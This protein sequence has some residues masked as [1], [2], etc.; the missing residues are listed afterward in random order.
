MQKKMK[1]LSATLPEGSLD[2][3]GPDD[4]FAKVMGKD[5]YGDAV[6]Y[7]LGVRASD[8]WGVV[9]GRSACRRENTALKSKCEELNTTVEQLRAEVLE[10]KGSRD[11]SIVQGL[12]SSHSPVATN[13]PPS[14]RVCFFLEVL[15][16]YFLFLT[17]ALH[18]C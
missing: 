5:R 9:P 13:E 1:E 17:I 18:L 11:S 12:T 8:V 15:Q 4:I 16:N 10:L 3:P 14:L 7:G 6:M 2:K